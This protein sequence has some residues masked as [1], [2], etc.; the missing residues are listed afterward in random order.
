[1]HKGRDTLT[2]FDTFTRPIANPFQLMM[3]ER[4]VDSLWGNLRGVPRIT[5]CYLL[6]TTFGKVNK[7]RYVIAGV[8]R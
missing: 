5:D 3:T 6:K 4:E 1:M 2:A 8:N 7:Y